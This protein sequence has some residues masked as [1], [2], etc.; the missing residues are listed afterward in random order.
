METQ[1]DTGEMLVPIEAGIPTIVLNFVF[2]VFFL[3][4][5]A[6]ILVDAAIHDQYLTIHN[7][8]IKQK[9]ISYTLAPPILDKVFKAAAGQ[10]LSGATV[11]TSNF[12]ADVTYSTIYQSSDESSAT[13][14]STTT[15]TS[16]TAP[17][18]SSS[19]SSSHSTSDLATK[20]GVGVGVPLG[21]CLVAALGY[22][23]WRRRRSNH[24]V[25]TE[26]M[27]FISEP[28]PK[29]SDTGPNPYYDS[30]EHEM[31]AEEHEI[32]AEEH[33]MPANTVAVELDG[34]SITPELPGHDRHVEENAP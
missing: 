2:M 1:T 6:E 19:S 11:T 13:S 30:V 7:L 25:N 26:E 17:T 23:F 32:Q 10:R 29:A 12:A 22:I 20:V 14:S 24:K 15:T 27:Q 3:S 18:S 5:D 28:N 16:N 34:Q 4:Y 21:V 9:A 8:Q 31:P 33:E